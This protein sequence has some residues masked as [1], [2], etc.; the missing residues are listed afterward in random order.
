MGLTIGVALF[1]AC[2]NFALWASRYS[3]KGF[4]KRGAKQGKS[5]VTEKE[6]RRR[7]GRYRRGEGKK[8]RK[9]REGEVT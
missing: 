2:R 6:K 5:S 8:E 3:L 1:C 4:C 7:R 9:E